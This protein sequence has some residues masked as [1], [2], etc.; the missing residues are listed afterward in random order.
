VL[1]AA[2]P[3][4]ESTWL[5][6]AA[7]AHAPASMP[8]LATDNWADSPSPDPATPVP[9]DSPSDEQAES[10]LLDSQP[11]RNVA[12]SSHENATAESAPVLNALDCAPLSDA[13]FAAYGALTDSGVVLTS[14]ADSTPGEPARADAMALVLGLTL[15]GYEIFRASPWARNKE[16]TALA[17]CSSLNG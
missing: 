8:S 7:Y 11:D 5:T 13:S 3:N 6:V 4:P 14:P 17:P 10:P 2:M 12:T 15:G 1:S 16:R 9:T